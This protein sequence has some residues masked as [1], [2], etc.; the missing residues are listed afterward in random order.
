MAEKADMF[1]SQIPATSIGLV[2][3]GFF[4]IILGWTTC[5]YCKTIQC[6][7]V[8]YQGIPFDAQDFSNPE[9]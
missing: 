3:W 2:V 4:N 1:L 6:N 5:F 8:Q 9:L 7:T